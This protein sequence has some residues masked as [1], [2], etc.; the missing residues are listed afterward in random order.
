MKCAVFGG[1]GFIGSA[2]CDRLLKEGHALRIF[3]RPKVPPYRIFENQEKVDW[4]EGD[5]LSTRDLDN[6]LKGMDVVF[7]LVSTTF[8]KNSNQNPIYDVESNL[9]GSLRLLDSMVRNGVSRIVFISSGGT[10]YGIPEYLPVDEKHP[11][12]PRVSYGITK[13]AIEK[14]L[15]LYSDLHGIKPV[16][17]RVSNPFGSKQRIESAQGAAT[18]FL[19]KAMNDEQVEIW[20][21]GT[22]TRDYLHVSDVAEAFIKALEYE[23]ARS[24]FNIGSGV[25]TSVNQLLAIIER[26]VE[27]P[28]RRVHLSARSFD[29]PTSIL[30]NELARKE[31]SWIPTI[32]I[33]EGIRVT[34][35]EILGQLGAQPV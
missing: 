33:E 3:E 22:V 7:H 2:V 15:Q 12:N 5:M 31:L 6:C 4:V 27:R 10:V 35:R 13:L 1:G 32:S 21:D 26:I 9:V 8:P 29:I 16:I 24:V 25:G 19:R 23:G 34:A 17:L 18:A 30:N 28:V 14:Y 20:G 11:T